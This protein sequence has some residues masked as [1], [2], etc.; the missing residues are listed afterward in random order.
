[1]VLDSSMS[2]R[3]WK[4]RLATAAVDQLFKILRPEDEAALVTFSTGVRLALPWVPATRLPPVNWDRWR[5]GGTTPLID[6]MQRA[7]AL[8]NEAAKPR[9]VVLV[10]SDGLDN[11]SRMSVSQIATTR[12]QSETMV[13]AVRTEELPEPPD[14]SA[15]RSGVPV[16]KSDPSQDVL[17]DL[18][19]DSGGVVYSAA[20]PQRAEA[21]ARAFVDDIESQ[22]VIGYV[23]KRPPDGTYR[24]VKVEAIDKPWT[25]RHRGGYL[26]QPIVP[27]SQ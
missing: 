12:R 27:R 2:M 23:P 19:G 24:R 25:V 20:V 5:V 9:A 8:V 16:F 4:L 21:S 10:V 17:V 7:I 11:D 3:G 15:R 14:N 26:A 18:V 22:Y 13:Y 6:A 1:V